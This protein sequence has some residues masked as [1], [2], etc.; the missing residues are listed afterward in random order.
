MEETNN[1]FYSNILAGKRKCSK[2]PFKSCIA[3]CGDKLLL[4]LNW[5]CPAIAFIEWT[6]NQPPIRLQVFIS[7]S[8]GKNEKEM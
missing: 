1:K 7:I 6:R 5:I 2:W 3:W 4:D 8:R